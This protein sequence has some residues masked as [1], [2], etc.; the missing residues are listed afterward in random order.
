MARESRKS[1]L[2]AHIDGDDVDDDE[3]KVY[4]YMFIYLC[5]IIALIF[6]LNLE[7]AEDC[8]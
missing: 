6:F 7:F 5:M 2:S 3:L 1:V 8:E 4:C